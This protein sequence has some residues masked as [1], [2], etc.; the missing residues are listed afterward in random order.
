V[1]FPNTGAAERSLLNGTAE[2]ST[3]RTQHR[4]FPRTASASLWTASPLADFR[5]T[6]SPFLPR[7]EFFSRRL[8]GVAARVLFKK[9]Q[10]PYA[11][12]TTPLISLAEPRLAVPLSSPHVREYQRPAHGGR[13]L[14]PTTTRDRPVYFPCVFGPRRRRWGCSTFCRRL[15]SADPSSDVP[16]RDRGP[17]SQQHAHEELSHRFSLAAQASLVTPKESQPRPRLFSGVA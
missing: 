8:A 13:A 14:P 17:C 2:R 9:P 3:R 1:T 7:T 16:N 10:K 6:L 15:L 4:A 5:Q 11:P 12:W